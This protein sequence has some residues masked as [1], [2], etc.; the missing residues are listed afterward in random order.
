MDLSLVSVDSTVARAHHDAA[1][2]AM[3]EEVLEA[4]EKA[5]EDEKGAARG[6]KRRRSPQRTASPATPAGKNGG[7]SGAGTG[8]A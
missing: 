7:A 6:D 3:R 4:L 2:T 1:G 5:A 8:P